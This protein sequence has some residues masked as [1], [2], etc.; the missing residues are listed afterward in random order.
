MTSK[1]GF[2]SPEVCRIAGVAPSTLDYWVRTKL[3]APSLRKPQGKRWTRYWSVTDL[4]TVRSVKALRAAGCPL[5]TVRV[6]KA[7]VEAW[8]ENMHAATLVWDGNDVIEV[9]SSGSLRSM[10]S[11]PD[12]QLLH[13][14]S[15]PLK[16]W[17]Q[18][19]VRSAVPIDQAI[20]KRRPD[21][22]RRGKAASA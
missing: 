22:Q 1:S 21:T 18:D 14:M 3:V 5:R 12:Q 16:V 7:R 9:S 17:H 20:L 15:L 4:V 10:V 6:V 2:S 11:R 8:G 19:A 13:V